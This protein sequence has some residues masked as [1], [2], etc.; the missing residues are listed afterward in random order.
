MAASHNG[1]RDTKPV[2]MG[3]AFQGKGWMDLHV[4]WVRYTKDYQNRVG[5]YYKNLNFMDNM[6]QHWNAIEA[7]IPDTLPNQTESL[8]SQSI[9]VCRLHVDE[10]TCVFQAGSDLTEKNKLH[11]F[12]CGKKAGKHSTTVFSVDN[13]GFVT[14][15]QLDFLA[16][17]VVTAGCGV[18]SKV[19]MQCGDKL[20][21][22]NIEPECSD[23]LVER[24]AVDLKPNSKLQ[25]ISN[26]V[27]SVHSGDS[28]SLYDL[29]LQTRPW[30]PHKAVEP[31]AAT[32]NAAQDAKSILNLQIDPA[33]ITVDEIDRYENLMLGDGAQ[34][35][36]NNSN[37]L[38][39]DMKPSW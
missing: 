18:D 30:N 23:L 36:A 31:Q 27:I 6:H 4:N 15:Q 5:S 1:G 19:V 28:I 20:K 16:G 12:V 35:R 25:G 39:N 26:G 8:R 13:K 21:L 33:K 38:T 17:E 22:F 7:M 24:C 2:I 37:S 29:Q 14:Y 34:G 3:C 9:A 32:A 11:I 10:T